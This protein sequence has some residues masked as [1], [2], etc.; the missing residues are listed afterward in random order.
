LKGK[1]QTYKKQKI[2]GA[3]YNENVVKT[4]PKLARFVS[5][6]DI[7][8]HKNMLISKVANWALAGWSHIQN[9]SFCI[10]Q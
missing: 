10:Y 3:S 4:N 5:N 9:T 8:W 7:S 2:W 6:E 1:K